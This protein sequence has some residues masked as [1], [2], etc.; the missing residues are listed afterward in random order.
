MDIVDSI[1]S[2]EIDVVKASLS[3]KTFRKRINMLQALN[4][5][6][7]IIPSVLDENYLEGIYPIFLREYKNTFPTQKI[8]WK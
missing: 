6:P 4:I 5:N 8:T 2:N 3:P 1:A 7:F